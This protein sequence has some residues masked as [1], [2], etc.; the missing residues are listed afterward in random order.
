MRTRARARAPDELH[1]ERRRLAAAAAAARAAAAAAAVCGGEHAQ[2]HG[3]GRGAADGVAR[4]AHVAREAGGVLRLYESHRLAVERLDRTA[5]GRG[6][7]VGER[8]VEG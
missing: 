4:L 5:R 8:R 2:Q 1:F 3:D 6:E 7:G